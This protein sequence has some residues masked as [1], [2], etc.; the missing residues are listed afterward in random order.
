[1]NKLESIAVR[2]LN[3]PYPWWLWPSVLVLLAGGALGASLTFYPAQGDPSSVLI[4]GQTFGGE[5]G[6]KQAIGLPCPQCGMTR[7]WVHLARGRVVEAFT[8]NAAGALLLLWILIGGMIGAARLVTGRETLF[9]PPWGLLLAWVLF[10]LIV[11][12][13]GLWVARMIGWNMLPEYLG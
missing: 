4:L 8:F 6:M 12:Y 7:S 2:A 5:C 10:W 1:M 13:M 3:G 11:P 9:R